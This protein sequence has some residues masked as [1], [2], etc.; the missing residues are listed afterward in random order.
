M[1]GL[2]RATI[3]QIANVVDIAIADFII[4]TVPFFH[5]HVADNNE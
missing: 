4:E 2:D 3:R 1:T 5:L